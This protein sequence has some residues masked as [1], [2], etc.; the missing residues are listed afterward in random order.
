MG[1]PQWIIIGI[2]ALGMLLV[3][4]KHGKPR[5]AENFWIHLTAIAITYALLLWGGFFG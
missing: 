1:A 4:H 5:R 3:A 2:T